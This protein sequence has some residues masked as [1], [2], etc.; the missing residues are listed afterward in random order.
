[1]TPAEQRQYAC[2]TTLIAMFGGFVA[3]LAAALMG[4]L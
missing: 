2:L 4:V 3:I 1:V